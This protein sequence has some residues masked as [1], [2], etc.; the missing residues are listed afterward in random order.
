MESF[1]KDFFSK[2]NQIRKLRI[3]SYL[4]KKPLQENFIFREMAT[5]KT[6]SIFFVS[7]VMLL[8]PLL[9]I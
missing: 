2:C 9:P 1:I 6:A 7:A 5:F 4:L 3:W 8:K